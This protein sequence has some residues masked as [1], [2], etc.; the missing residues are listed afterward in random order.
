MDNGSDPLDVFYGE[1]PVVVDV[2]HEWADQATTFEF[3]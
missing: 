1:P 3:K 2:P